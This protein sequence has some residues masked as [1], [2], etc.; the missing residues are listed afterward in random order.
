[1]QFSMILSVRACIV[2]HVS[3]Y[4]NVFLMQA[5]GTT[6]GVNRSH[7]WP[8]PEEWSLEDAATVPYAYAAAYLALVV[9]GRIQRSHRV[10]IHRGGTP[11]GQA[12]IAVAVQH[13]CEVFTSFSPG[14]HSTVRCPQLNDGNVLSLDSPTFQ[15][16]VLKSSGGQAMDVILGAISS[17]KLRESLHVLKSNGQLVD[18]GKVK[19]TDQLGMLTAFGDKWAY[20]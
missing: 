1:M 3:V 10:L 8:V 7:L 19:L 16:D 17:G 15:W 4:C 14:A 9:R 5:I 6:I 2:V 18:M 20:I 13:G 11:L 12:A